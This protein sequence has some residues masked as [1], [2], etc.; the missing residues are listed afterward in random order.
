MITGDHHPV[1]GEIQER[2][3]VDK[4]QATPGKR[5]CR[6]NTRLRPPTS[7]W[8]PTPCDS[9]YK[10]VSTLVTIA[11]TSPVTQPV[12]ISIGYYSAAGNDRI[13][14]SY[15][16]ASG[17]RFLYNDKEGD[18]KPRTMTIS[19]SCGNPKPAEASKRLP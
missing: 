4:F 3:I 15:V 17:N 1:T 13:T 10:S 5:S 7:P 19:I 2:G 11:L 18:G 14:Q 6:R 12:E 8:W 16:R 9:L